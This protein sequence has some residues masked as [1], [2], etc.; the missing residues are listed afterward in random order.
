MKTIKMVLLTSLTF[1]AFFVATQSVQAQKNAIKIHPLSGK[2]AYER[3]FTPHVS[4][5][6]AIKVLPI[7]FKVNDGEDRVGLA[8]YTISPEVRFYLGK[9]RETKLAGFY[10]APYLKGGITELRGTVTSDTDL[11]EKVKFRGNTIGGGATVG[12]QWTMN[13]GFNIGTAVGYGFSR[14]TFDDVTVRY[15]DGTVEKEEF[16]GLNLGGAWPQFRFSLGYAF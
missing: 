6:I 14:F 12:W 11:K 4:G 8:N 1:I 10:I 16:R 5:Q 2:L 15:S 13:N 7:F 3:M 9:E